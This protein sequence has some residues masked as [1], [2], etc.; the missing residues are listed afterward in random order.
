MNQGVASLI[1]YL[2]I[3]LGN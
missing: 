1:L 2:T 3:L